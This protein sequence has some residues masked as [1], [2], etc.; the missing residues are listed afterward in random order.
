LSSEI[1]VFRLQGAAKRYAG[2]QA[3]A[4][5]D[6]EVAEGTCSVLIGP[7]GCGKTTLLRL[8]NGL[9]RPDDGVVSFRGVPIGEGNV[10]ELR[11][12]MGTSS[13]T[14]GCFLTWTPPPT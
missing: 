8:L 2:V 12:K 13:R 5:T 9:V 3:L 1:V 7:S 4:P 10:R 11:R 6:L 14:A